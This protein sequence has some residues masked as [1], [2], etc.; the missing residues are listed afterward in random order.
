MPE[1]VTH[2]FKT[3]QQVYSI[4]ELKFPL[5]YEPLTSRFRQQG[6]QIRIEHPKSIYENHPRFIMTPYQY[7]AN[8]VDLSFHMS[9]RLLLGYT[10]EE[11]N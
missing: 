7:H 11:L 10:L 1:L 2:P 6:L 5:S 3:K 8:R 9:F 4:Y